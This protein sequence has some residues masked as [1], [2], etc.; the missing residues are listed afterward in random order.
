MV[1]GLLGVVCLVVVVLCFDV[2]GFV[3][4]CVCGLLCVY[5][6]ACG[7]FGLDLSFATVC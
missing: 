4:I 3:G 2:C 1:C 5:G 7:V 6:F